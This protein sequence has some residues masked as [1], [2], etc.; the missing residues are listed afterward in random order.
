MRSY[1]VQ[2]NNGGARFDGRV[3][4]RVSVSAPCSTMHHS[5]RACR[6]SNT[7]CLNT[8]TCQ[9]N[10]IVET[11]IGKD[12][13][14]VTHIM[15]LP[16]MCYAERRMPMLIISCTLPLHAKQTC[17]STVDLNCYCGIVRATESTTCQPDILIIQVHFCCQLACK[18]G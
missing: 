15:L 16:C 3:A 12:V 18:L 7:K 5:G 10:N 2:A 4:G 8:H 14:A 6:L 1:S 13:V 11:F 17:N 9:H